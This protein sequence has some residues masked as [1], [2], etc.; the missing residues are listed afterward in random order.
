[1]DKR[2]LYV[3]ALVSDAAEKQHNIQ[4][5]IKDGVLKSFSVGFRVLDQKYNPDDDSSTITDLELLELSVVSIPA[6]QTSLFSIRKNFDTEEE[7]KAYCDRF[8]KEN[9]EV[10]ED[11]KDIFTGISSFDGDHYHTFEVDSNKNGRTVFTSH[12]VKS[13]IHEVLDGEIQG[14]NDHEHSVKV[15]DIPQ[16]KASKEVEE[17][18]EEVEFDLTP[19]TSKTNIETIVEEVQEE[20]EEKAEAS[21]K[22]ESVEEMTEEKVGEED[23]EE[24]TLSSDPYTPIPF[25]N[26]LSLETSRIKNGD[27]VNYNKK[28]WVVNKIATRESP[29]F[30]FNEV[31]LH[32]QPKKSDPLAV[33]ATELSVVNTWDFGTGF[34]LQLLNYNIDMELN[35]E[36][37]ALIRDKFTDLVNLEDYEIYEL[38]NHESVKANRDYQDT[39]NKLLNLKLSPTTQWNDT[40]YIVANHICET[41]EKLKELN[42]SSTDDENSEVNI[43]LK[44]HGHKVETKEIE[45]ENENMATQPDGNPQV[46]RTNKT[47]SQPV[48]AA[49]RAEAQEPRVAELIEKTGQAIM[50][51][52]D[53]KLNDKSDSQVKAELEEIRA[54]R[55]ELLQMKEEV[56]VHTKSKM[57]FHESKQKEQ[58][59]PKQMAD[60]Y[61]LAK[62]MGKSDSA[63]EIFD[64]KLGMRMKAV[65]SVDAFLSNFSQTVQEEMEQELIIAP[66]LNRVQVDARNFRVPVADEDTNLNVAQF[67]SGTF[68][69]SA[70]DTG[71]VPTSV[72]NTISA[73]TFTPH[74]FMSATH[75]AR[76]EEE[77]TVLP[78]IGFLR[79]GAARRMARSIDKSLLRGDGTITSGAANTGPADYTSVI[80]GIVNRA[81]AVAGDGLKIFTGANATQA[82]AINIATART[83]MGKYGIR[84]NTNDLVYITSVEGYNELVQTADF[85]TVDT[86]GPQA[87]YHTG[88]L[89]AI[90]GIPVMISEFMDSKGA[91]TTNNNSVGVLV[92]KPGFLV[93]ERRAV[94]VETEYQPRQQVTAVYM[95]TRLD[96]QALTTVASA[97]LSNS[98]AFAVSIQTGDGT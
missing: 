91:S 94:L 4:S 80:N 53:E 90:W 5:L 78:L 10:E 55:A 81:E 26:C 98:Y 82:S 29:S 20:E 27:L 21:Q 95:S 43:A 49:P 63:D 83:R 73:V 67:P 89:G 66:M 65:T 19:E 51:H 39:V 37:R 14:I 8:T 58:F 70:Y 24:D 92:Y 88:V 30:V 71:N 59:T 13:H 22:S 6:N 7:Y 87:T 33:K 3:E 36:K 85:R 62:A 61:F 72:Q 46:V 12:G 45:E 93:A 1:M 34:D 11:T 47:D 48:S 60:A 57:E 25:E 23:E 38:K 15:I 2:G 75:I 56:A 42:L 40:N 54:L 84:V 96:M 64:T 52:A 41:I 44:I 32:N 97:A 17:L 86:F 31:D 35:D 77:D 68:S 79:A 28:R 74:K 18:E 50:D 9:E 16:A 69:I 76:D